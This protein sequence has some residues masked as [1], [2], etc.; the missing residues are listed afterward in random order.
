MS[1][2]CYFRAAKFTIH[3]ETTNAHTFERCELADFS[4]RMVNL[5]LS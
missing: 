4:T 3:T 1:V 5:N 2:Q